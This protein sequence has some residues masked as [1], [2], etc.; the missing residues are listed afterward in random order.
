MTLRWMR[1]NLSLQKPW[2][3]PK[4]I[5]TIRKINWC[6]PAFISTRYNG[7]INHAVLIG[8]VTKSNAYFYGHTNNRNAKSNDYG[9][10]EYFND[11]PK[12]KKGTMVVFY[13][14]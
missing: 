4:P 12:N 1:T 7:K 13:I 8:R 14:V 9:L 3:T 6:I 11:A 10:V 2:F 5:F